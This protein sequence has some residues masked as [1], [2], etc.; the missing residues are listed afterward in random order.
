MGGEGVDL[1]PVRGNARTYCG[2]CDSRPSQVWC[3]SNAWRDE[4]RGAFQESEENNVMVCT[5]GT[6]GVGLN[7]TR[8]SHVVHFDRCWN[9]AREAQAT[10][11]AHR[12]GQCRTVVVHRLVSQGTLEERLASELER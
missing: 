1:Y 7:L 8:A 3:S 11:R 12:I 5:L 2:D 9:P 6:G 10:D 4:G